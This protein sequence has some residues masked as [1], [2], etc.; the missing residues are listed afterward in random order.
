MPV[1]ALSFGAHYAH[2]DQFAQTHQGR[3][4]HVQGVQAFGLRDGIEAFTD[5]RVV[6]GEQGGEQLL[7]GW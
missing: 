5:G 2:P 3:A 4:Q 6:V 7:G 1:A